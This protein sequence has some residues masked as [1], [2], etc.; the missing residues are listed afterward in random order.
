MDYVVIRNYMAIPCSYFNLIYLDE[1]K[2]GSYNEKNFDIDGL[3]Y[4]INQ[5]SELHSLVINSESLEYVLN[6]YEELDGR[7]LEELLFLDKNMKTPIHAAI[8][9]KSNKSINILLKKLAKLNLNN[10]GNL[11]GIF[12][13]LLDFHSFQEYLN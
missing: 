13:D 7:L 2:N 5:Q 4:I 3:C 11:R 9:S 12:D 8:E 6:K 1:Y 10:S